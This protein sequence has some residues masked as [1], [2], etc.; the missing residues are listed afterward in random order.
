MARSGLVLA[1]A[2]AMP[3]HALADAPTGRICMAGHSSTTSAELLIS[4]DGIPIGGLKPGTFW[5]I[6][7]EPGD[8]VL[9][10]DGFVSWEECLVAN[11]YGCVES[12][13][14]SA[15]LSQDVDFHVPSGT[16][17]GLRLGIE[18]GYVGGAPMD[19]RKMANRYQRR[20]PAFL[21]RL[22]TIQS[23]NYDALAAQAGGPPAPSWE[24]AARIQAMR[25]HTEP[26]DRETALAVY[27]CEAYADADLIHL[28][29]DAPSGGPLDEALYA[30]GATCALSAGKEARLRAAA[31]ERARL[32]ALPKEPLVDSL[33]RAVL[34][35]E[36]TDSARNFAGLL[37]TSA[38]ADLDPAV[39]AALVQLCMDARESSSAM[40]DAVSD[41][42]DADVL[43][44]FAEAD[45]ECGVE[46]H[47]IEPPPGSAP[48]SPPPEPA[49]PEPA[50]AP[51]LLSE[52][53]SPTEALRR[54]ALE[55]N[56][57]TS[58]RRFARILAGEADRSLDQDT[59]AHLIQLCMDAGTESSR[60][61]EAIATSDDPDVVVR[62]TEAGLTC[63]APA[64]ATPPASRS[65]AP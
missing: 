57:S 48:P 36:P 53:R 60:M 7:L 31:V 12:L 28:A 64:P 55:T 32:A 20:T 6:D 46:R 45:L 41:S 9:H 30:A 43:V 49:P 8:H 33:R 59:T 61:L 34:G 17:G 65:P 11:D 37:V 16:I 14:R 5:C 24:L 3:P 26:V 54:A 2:C 56:P 25:G 35:V 40:L 29:R 15:D 50:E 51:E 13:P 44:R 10:I 39:T 21:D 58:A 63:G 27:R 62:F 23:A 47:V 4:V 52:P 18:N 22:K 1:L 38:E 19:P 42:E